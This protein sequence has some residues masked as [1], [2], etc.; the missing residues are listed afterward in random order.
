MRAQV[1]KEYTRRAEPI[2]V[3]KCVDISAKNLYNIYVIYL[4]VIKGK[5]SA[6]YG[7]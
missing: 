2:D 6:F 3:K 7:I 5:G 4:Y 1:K